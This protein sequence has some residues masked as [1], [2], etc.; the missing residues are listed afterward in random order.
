MGQS[1]ILQM[2][3]PHQG[4]EAPSSKP[5]SYLSVCEKSLSACIYVCKAVCQLTI[6]S[7]VFLSLS[8]CLYFCV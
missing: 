4:G 1:G 8:A 5:Y 6:S 7:D 3:K 2:E